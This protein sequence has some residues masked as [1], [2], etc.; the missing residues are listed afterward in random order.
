MDKPSNRINY[1]QILRLRVL[2][3]VEQALHLGHMIRICPDQG[4]GY[5][6]IIES[7]KLKYGAWLRSSASPGSYKEP[8]WGKLEEIEA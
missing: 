2:I 7:G 8:R 6:Q 4:K 1:Y 3:D 5:R